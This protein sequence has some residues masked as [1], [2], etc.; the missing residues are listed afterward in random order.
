M[1]GA[2][3]GLRRASPIR[4]SS[5]SRDAPN[6]KARNASPPR[7]GL[8]MNVPAASKGTVKKRPPPVPR[9]F[10][11]ANEFYG[12]RPGMVFKA[13]SHGVGY[14]LDSNAPLLPL[15]ARESIMDAAEVFA[16]LPMTMQTAFEARDIAA[17]DAALAALPPAEAEVH[18]HHCVASGLWDP[19]GGGSEVPSPTGNETLTSLSAGSPAAAD[20]VKR[21]IAYAKV[22]GNRVAA[23]ELALELRAPQQANGSEAMR[24]PDAP[25]PT[26]ML[27]ERASFVKPRSGNASPRICD[28][29]IAT[30]AAKPV[31]D[32]P[33]PQRRAKPPVR[34]AATSAEPAADEPE[35]QPTPVLNTQLVVNKAKPGICVGTAQENQKLQAMG[36]QLEGLA[37]SLRVEQQARVEAE[38]EIDRMQAQISCLHTKLDDADSFHSGAMADVK[39]ALLRLHEEN[40]R[41]RLTLLAAETAATHGAS[42]AVPNSPEPATPSPV[43]TENSHSPIDEPVTPHWAVTGIGFSPSS[44]DPDVVLVSLPQAIQT[45]FDSLDV[46]ELHTALAALPPAEAAEHMRRCVASG[47]WDPNGG[48]S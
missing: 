13:G 5:P 27:F 12:T 6:L 42:P 29:P 3:T 4:S 35:P 36:E 16:L 1:A 39:E 18:M 41:L 38:A 8:L 43:R 11:V 20:P 46:N 34:V 14:Y 10:V 9:S 31:A 30:S 33:L 45:A 22:A 48:I 7:G 24:S 25:P 15:L 32:S 19:E 21:V 40:A 37:T 26:G 2:R 23:A 17:L 28:S 47:L 44:L